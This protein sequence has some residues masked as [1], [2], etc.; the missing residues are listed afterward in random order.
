VFAFVMATT[1]IENYDL[2]PSYCFFSIAWLL[3]A[4]N[5]ERVRHPSPWRG[6]LTIAGMW[7][8][9]LSGK[10]MPVEISEHENE[11]AIRAYEEK[12]EQHFEMER[13]KLLERQEAA[14][15]LSD[16]LQGGTTQPEAITD[17]N[18]TKTGHRSINPLAIV[19]LPIQ[20]ILGQVCRVVRIIRSV[21][22]WDESH[23]A[24]ILWNVCIALGVACLWVPWS[25]FTRWLLRILAW[26][27]LGPWMKLVDFFVLPKL[28]GAAVDE[29]EALQN[30]AKTQ[31]AN[32]GLAKE[33]ILKQREKILKERAMK[34]Y[35]FGRF[36]VKVPRFKE[37]RYRDT[38]L[39]ESYATSKIH[40]QEVKIKRRSHGQT[41]EGDMVPTWGD[42]IDEVIDDKKKI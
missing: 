19:L 40:H 23:T 33:A 28:L 31:L 14:K 32:L 9:V 22:T 25:F 3:A 2:Y 41:L 7:Y 12:I 37:F 17:E 21:L 18:E 1:L 35:M 42:A 27:L 6:S 39:P 20:Q 30:L 10:T 11:A 13:E 4:T 26:T 15:A 8:A 16:F 36:S 38:P 29:D 34:K 5:E 24:F